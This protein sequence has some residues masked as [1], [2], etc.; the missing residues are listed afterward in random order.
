[1]HEVGYS[2]DKMGSLINSF[3]QEFEDFQSKT[4]PYA[5]QEYIFRNHVDLSSG[6][7]HFWHKKETLRFTIIFGRFA[8]RVCSKILGIGSAEHSWGDVKHLK[9]NQQSHLSSRQLR[10]KPQFLVL[11]VWNYQN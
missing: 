1:M 7:I 10:C 8:C 3:W 9:T 4:C 5:N 6:N 11:V 2:E